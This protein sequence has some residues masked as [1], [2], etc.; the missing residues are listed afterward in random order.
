MEKLGGVLV[1]IFHNVF[2]CEQYPHFNHMLSLVT[3]QFFP[4]FR[5]D[6]DLEIENRE[7]RAAE[8]TLFIPRLIQPCY[9]S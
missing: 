1:D 5:S 4:V 8:R 3:G 7:Q 6:C 2:S 9:I